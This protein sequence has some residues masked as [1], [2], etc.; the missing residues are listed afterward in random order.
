M[1]SILQPPYLIP[2]PV[3]R[4]LHIYILSSPAPTIPLQVAHKYNRKVYVSKD[5]MQILQCCGLTPEYSRLLTTDHLEAN[6]HAVRHY[7][8]SAS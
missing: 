4:S 6:M 7:L 8:R 5:K 3:P 2:Q 1:A